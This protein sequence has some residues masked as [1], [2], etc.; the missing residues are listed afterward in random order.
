MA[1][2]TTILGWEIPWTQ[3]PGGLQFMGSQRVRQGSQERL[4]LSLSVPSRHFVYTTNIQLFSSVQSLSHV[5]LCDP[6]NCSM[7][8]LPVHHQ[9]L[10]FTQTRI[11]RV[12]DAIQPSH[13]LSS[14]S[15]PARN[16]SQHQSL[17]Q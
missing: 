7:P 10:E 1:T 3:E 14:P 8:G 9:L 15:P 6:M 5:R 12:G 17:F 4:T 13:A 16:P 2:H 11:H